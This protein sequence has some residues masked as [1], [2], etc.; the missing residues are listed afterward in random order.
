MKKDILTYS[1]LELRKKLHR[2]AMK[3]LRD[4]DDA[5]DA[6]QDTFIKLW[7]AGSVE[8]DAEAGNKLFVVLRNLCIDR[9]RKPRMISLVEAPENS[10]VAESDYAEDMTNYESLLLKGV[11]ET[12][13]KVYECVVHQGLDYEEISALL[14]MTVDAVKTNMYRARKRI[15]ENYKKLNL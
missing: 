7:S 12:Q 5:K 10:L 11:P 9:L 8:S 14:N 3:F 2:T 15:Y 1:F 4:D 6:L 13:R